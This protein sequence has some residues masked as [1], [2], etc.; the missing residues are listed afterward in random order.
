MKLNQKEAVF[1]ATMSVL[2]E[3]SIN[4]EGNIADVVTK[5][6]RHDI[7]AIVSEGFAKGEIELRDTNSNREKVTD[8]KLMTNYVSGLVN[9]WHRKDK[10]L[11]GGMQYATKN[12]GSRVSDPQ[13]KA[14]KALGKKFVGT[15]KS[16]KI[17]AE[18]EKRTAELTS[19]KVKAVEV[20][21]TQV[22]EELKSL[23]G[24]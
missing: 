6:I 3:N 10:R 18:I 1:A 24:L 2:S 5:E 9:N 16:S 4:L 15:D 23:L 17:Q 21:M 22:P 11:N 7:C 13:L 8:P 12:P 20:D 19:A 14:L